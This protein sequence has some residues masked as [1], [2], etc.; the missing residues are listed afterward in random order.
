MVDVG[1]V[2]VVTERFLDGTPGRMVY[3]TIQATTK[4]P[5]GT[6]ASVKWQIHRMSSTAMRA[7]VVCVC[8][9]VRTL[10]QDEGR[11]PCTLCKDCLGFRAL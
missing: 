4:T 7:V 6:I 8:S 9:H 2:V 3:G 10:H 5:I 11:G 1:D